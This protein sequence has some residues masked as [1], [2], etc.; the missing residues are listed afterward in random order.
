[1]STACIVTES[2]FAVLYIIYRWILRLVIKRQFSFS[3]FLEY[4]YI[5]QMHINV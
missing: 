1:M 4:M 5:I 2:I 3:I